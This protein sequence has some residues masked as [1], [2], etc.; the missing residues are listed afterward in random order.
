[1]CADSGAA[2][3]KSVL[4]DLHPLRSH[5]FPLKMILLRFGWWEIRKTYL[6]I[7]RDFPPN[8]GGELINMDPTIFTNQLWQKH[9]NVWHVKW[10]SRRRPRVRESPA[11]PSPVTAQSIAVATSGHPHGR[12]TAQKKI[13]LAATARLIVMCLVRS[14]KDPMTCWVYKWLVVITPYENHCLKPPTRYD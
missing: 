14:S 10:Y 8:L 2:L 1:M 7:A 12:R 6:W 4:R 9:R 11:T 3:D 5:R 13:A